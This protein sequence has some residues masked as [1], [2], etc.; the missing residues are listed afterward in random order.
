[1]W[2]LPGGL[3]GEDQHSPHV[4]RLA[5]VGAPWQA[6]PAGGPGLSPVEDGSGAAVALSP[7]HARGANLPA[8]LRPRWLVS[9][10]AGTGEELDGASRFPRP[11]GQ[12]VP[13]ALEGA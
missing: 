7:G 10:P 4:D 11:G 13:G 3:P 2:R 5:R 6:E 1:M 9:P 8:A 12:V